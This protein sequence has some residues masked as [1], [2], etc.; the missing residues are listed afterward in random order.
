MNWIYLIAKLT[1]LI[2][3]ISDKG[4][5]VFFCFYF[6]RITV[7]DAL[8]GWTWKTWCQVSRKNFVISQT[9]FMARRQ[10]NGEKSASLPYVRA[11]EKCII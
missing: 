1:S 10:A 9:I 11:A 8:F 6:P 7:C 3:Y 5:Y 2:K 4:I